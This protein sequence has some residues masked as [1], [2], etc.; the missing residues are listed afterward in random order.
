MRILT[1]SMLVVIFSLGSAIFLLPWYTSEGVKMLAP[2]HLTSLYH[3][4]VF[5][6]GAGLISCELTN[7]L[8]PPR[9]SWGRRL[10]LNL[11]VVFLLGLGIY[12]LGRVTW[13]TPELAYPFD[14]ALSWPYLIFTGMLFTGYLVG[15]LLFQPDLPSQQMSDVLWAKSGS[16]KEFRLRQMWIAKPFAPFRLSSL[17]AREQSLV[18][19]QP[20]LFRND[21]QNI[22]YTN[23]ANVRAI[24]YR[25]PICTVEVNSLNGDIHVIINK[26]P[27]RKAERFAE[28]VMDRVDLVRTG[29]H[30]TLYHP[31]VYGTSS[32]EEPSDTE[33]AEQ[34]TNGVMADAPPEQKVKKPRGFIGP[35]EISA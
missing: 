4:L 28:M 20:T 3:W 23:I 26:M 21:V 34:L 19:K 10:M 33:A 15:H 1:R 5:A 25:I 32:R 7:L 16:G 30:S 11:V 12:T 22:A 2:L 17:T 6:A 9:L 29:T 18:V 14:L 24:G 35:K 13:P 8:V 27:R 31:S